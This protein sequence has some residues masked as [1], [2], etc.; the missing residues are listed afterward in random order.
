MGFIDTRVYP[1]DE[2]AIFEAARIFLQTEGRLL[3]PESAYA[4]RAM[5]DEA[6]QVKKTAKKTV[7]VV[8]VSGTAFLDFGE[9]NGYIN[10]A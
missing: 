9:K 7:I 6:L 8:S 1:R 4:I 5:I 2:K 3:A 10:L